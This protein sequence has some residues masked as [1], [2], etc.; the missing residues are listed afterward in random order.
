MQVNTL[1]LDREECSGEGHS[2]SVKSWINKY[3]SRV[4]V[5]MKPKVIIYGTQWCGDCSHSKDFLNS[6]QVGYQWIDVDDEPDGREFVLK[7]N[8]GKLIVPTIVFEDS[9]ILVEPTNDELELKLQEQ[10]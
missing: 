10:A 1:T 5:I 2:S 4:Y 7:V 9:S 6:I 8:N 3:D